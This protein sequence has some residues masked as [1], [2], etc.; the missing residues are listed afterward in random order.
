MTAIIHIDMDAF[1]A[2]VEQAR[3]PELRGCPV[4]V[5]GRPGS[6]GVVA[7]ASYE[8]RAMGVRTAMPVA[9]ARRLC[10]QAVFLPVDRVAYSAVHRRL[11]EL[12]GRFTDLV[13]P[14]SIDEAFLDVTGSRRLFGPPQTIARRLQELVRDEH[15]LTCSLGIG[16]TKLLAKIASR[17]A[18][19]CGIG[20]LTGDDVGGRLRELPVGELWGIGPVTEERLRALGLT[21]VGALQDVPLSVLSAAFGRSARSLKHLAVGG[22]GSAVRGGHAA[23]R[24]L[25]HEV[26]FAEDVNDPEVLR[27]T[28]LSLTDATMSGLRAKGFS[29]RTVALKVRYSTFHTVTRRRSLPAPSTITRPVYDTVLELLDELDLRGRWVRLLGVAASNLHAK[30]FQLTF[31]DHWKQVAL[32]DAVDRVRAKYGSRALRLAAADLGPHGL[33]RPPLGVRADGVAL[34]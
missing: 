1:F 34:C 20:E 10:P 18:K 9:Q 15:D 4:V 8:A 5:G 7:T 29:A 16:P 30:A 19:P 32:S 12:Y 2:S 23:P 14:L 3:R 27:A 22:G 11:Q 13:E 21:T 25:G 31:D 28:L 24:S 6:R 17:L 33:S 26:T